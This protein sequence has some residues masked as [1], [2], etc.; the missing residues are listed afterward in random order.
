[1]LCCHV[2]RAHAR[3]CL[4]MGWP[5]KRRFDM[6]F[7][8]AAMLAQGGGGGAIQGGRGYWTSF[9]QTKIQV[10]NVELKASD[11]SVTIELS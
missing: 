7:G 8:T 1:M 3:P 6:T 10:P 5:L 4:S 9:R 2:C 11:D